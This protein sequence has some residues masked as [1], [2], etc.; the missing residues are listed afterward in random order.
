MMLYVVTYNSW[1]AYENNLTQ[2][3]AVFDTE[4]QAL[5]Y[6]KDHSSEICLDYKSSGSFFEIEPVELNKVLE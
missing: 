4:Q 1:E 2:L 6:V 3:R 5:D